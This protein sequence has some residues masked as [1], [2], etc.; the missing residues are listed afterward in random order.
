MTG[1][2]LT[3][4]LYIPLLLLYLEL[5]LNI[6]STAN[7]NTSMVADALIPKSWKVVKFEELFDVTFFVVFSQQ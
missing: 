6:L 5:L 2:G 7:T 3:P 1:Q 4:V